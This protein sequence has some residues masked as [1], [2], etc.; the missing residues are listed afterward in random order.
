MK[1]LDQVSLSHHFADLGDAFGTPVPPSPFERPDFIHANP[2]VMQQ[3]GIDPAEAANPAWAEYGCGKRLFHGSRPFAMKYTGHQFGVYNPDLGDGRALLLGELERDG[4]RWE[5]H[6][7]GAGKTPYSRF[8]DGRA[9]L[10]STIREYLGGEALYGLGIPT[11]RALCIVGSDEPVVREKIETGAMLIRVAE[12]HIRFGHFEYLFYT[13]QLEALHRLVEFTCARFLP[14]LEGQPAAEQAEALLRFTTRRSASLVAGWQA[15][16]F[17]HGVLN[18]DNMSIIGDTF[19]Y[20]PYGFL[21]DYEPNF[22]CNHSDHTGRYAF[23]QQPGVVLWN[24]NAL[25]HAFSAF[26]GAD[27]LRDCLEEFQPLLIDE[28]AA[29]MRTKLG[30]QQVED[31]DQHLCAELLQL[32]EQAQADYTLFFRALAH[33]R[34]ERPPASLQEIVPVA[35]HAA[36]EQWLNHYD[37]R[38][39][40][41]Q[42]DSRTRNRTMLAANPKYILRNYLAQKVIEAAEAHDFRPLQTLFGLLQAPFDEHPEHESWAAAPPPSGKHMPISCSS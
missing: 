38:L 15:A 8:G 18:T 27:T 19:D 22:I 34:G 9:V 1:K 41:E 7:K 2:A 12:T 39:T 20:G 14:E 11:T 33:Y 6:L 16:G 36:L 21:D 13:K 26:V 10:R 25:A 37:Q 4:T 31:G 40:H 32:L 24:L 42:S 28:Y 30:L 5:L 29:R 23:E 17:A 35:Q 3:L